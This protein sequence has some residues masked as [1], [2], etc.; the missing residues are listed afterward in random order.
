MAYRLQ[1]YQECE[2]QSLADPGL[3]SMTLP[4]M[5]K[6]R[7]HRRTLAK[8]AIDRRALDGFHEGILSDW[9]AIKQILDYLG[10]DAKYVHVTFHAGTGPP[11]TSNVIRFPSSRTKG[12]LAGKVR[13]K[14]HP[15]KRQSRVVRLLKR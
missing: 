3:G 11:D 1:A 12:E 14:T 13:I 15:E 4:T 9:Q 5:K 6:R 2:V 8:I 7:P 10:Y